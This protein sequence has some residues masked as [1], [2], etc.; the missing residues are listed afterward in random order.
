MKQVLDMQ[1]DRQT[2]RQTGEQTGRRSPGRRT[3]T[4]C[5]D[6]QSRPTLNAQ[7]MICIVHSEGV[8]VGDR[9]LASDVYF[10]K[11]LPKLS[12]SHLCSPAH[13]GSARLRSAFNCNHKDLGARTFN[14]G[15]QLPSGCVK[16]VY[17]N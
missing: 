5:A 15:S 13:S 14:L 7:V 9:Q 1:A 11:I 6:R 16:A 3:D 10:L 4:F 2:D 8:V 12:I 17:L